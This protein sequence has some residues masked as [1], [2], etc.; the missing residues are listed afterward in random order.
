MLHLKNDDIG[1]KHAIHIDVMSTSPESERFTII[2][3]RILTSPEA[4]QEYHK[5]L[6]TSI[7]NPH[8][9]FCHVEDHVL[10]SNTVIK[11]RGHQNTLV[12]LKVHEGIPNVM[13]ASECHVVN[14]V[15]PLFVHGLPAED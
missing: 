4:N 8:P 9:E 10:H 15:D 7:E 6:C 14:L 11:R 12:K 2:Q 13:Q 5:S 3:G 1:K